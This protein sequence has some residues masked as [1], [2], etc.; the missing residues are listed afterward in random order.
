MFVGLYW[1][2]SRKHETLNIGGTH[3]ICSG[4]SIGSTLPVSGEETMS[5]FINR[6]YFVVSVLS[7]H[8]KAWKTF[9]QKKLRQL[10]SLIISK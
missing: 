5:T 1:R 8:Q 7:A 10:H 6:S 3:S 9:C 4:S 2:F